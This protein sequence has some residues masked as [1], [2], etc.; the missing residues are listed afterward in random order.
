MSYRTARVAMPSFQLMTLPCLFLVWTR[1]PAGL[2][3]SPVTLRDLGGVLRDPVALLTVGFT[4]VFLGSIYMVFTYLPPLLSATMG[5]GRDGISLALLIFGSAVA[6]L[7][8]AMVGVIA[9]L[10]ALAVVRVIAEFT[11]VSIF[12]VNVIS[13]LGIG[14]SLAALL[15]I[16]L[17]SIFQKGIQQ[18]PM[19]V[20]PLQYA[21]GLLMCAVVVPF[22]PFEVEWSVGFIVPLLYMGVLISVGATLLLYRLIRMGNLVNVTSL[23]YLMPGCTALL[24]FLFLGNRMAALSLLGMG[25]IVLGLVFRQRG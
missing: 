4:V 15:C 19:D 23:F 16:T 21:I 25:A 14:L 10:G 7:M 5:Y 12:S 8:P 22:Q 18:S 3:F 24:D 1:V 11:E 20:L 17:G 2:R 13:L 6:A 9:M